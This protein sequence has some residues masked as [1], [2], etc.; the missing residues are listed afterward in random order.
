[1]ITVY[2]VNKNNYIV[3]MEPRISQAYNE[4]MAEYD[5]DYYFSKRSFSNWK[6]RNDEL[7]PKITEIYEYISKLEKAWAPLASPCKVYK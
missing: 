6:K 1:M 5:G 7:K 4:F 3:G 2:L